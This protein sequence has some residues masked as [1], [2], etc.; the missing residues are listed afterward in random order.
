MRHNSGYI[1]QVID[2]ILW[3]KVMTRQHALEMLTASKP[4]LAERFDV[5]RLELFG[6]TARAAASIGSDVDVLVAF[7]GLATSA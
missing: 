2:G 6:S 3:N 4:Q 7:D 5:V 1:T